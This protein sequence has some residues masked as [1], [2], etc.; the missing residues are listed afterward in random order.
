MSVM[1]LSISAMISVTWLPISAL[2]PVMWQPISEVLALMPVTWLPISALISVTWQPISEV[3]A[4]MPVTFRE[5]ILLPQR[6]NRHHLAFSRLLEQAIGRAGMEKVKWR[7]DNGKW[8]CHCTRDRDVQSEG[9][10]NVSRAVWRY[11]QRKD[12]D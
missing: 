1:W 6:H 7:S 11:C 5:P 4:L 12:E 10:L 9:E 2:M 8:L 3:L